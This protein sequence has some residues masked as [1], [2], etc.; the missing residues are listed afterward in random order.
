MSDLTRRLQLIR[1]DTTDEVGRSAS[2]SRHQVVQLLLRTTTGTVRFRKNV[3][4]L[5]MWLMG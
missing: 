3:Q 4:N 2:E 1:D 5:G